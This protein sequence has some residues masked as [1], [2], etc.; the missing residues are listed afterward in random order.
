MQADVLMQVLWIFPIYA[1]LGWCLEVIYASV[2]T[3]KFVNR[4]FLNGCIC[5]IYG[6]GASLMI[7]CLVPIE[8][9]L[10]VLFFGALL[11]GSLLE[12][13]GGFLLKHLFHITW[14]DY[15]DEPL[16][17]GGYICL[18][19]SLAWGV[20]GIFLVRIIHPPIADLVQITPPILRT[21]LL[22]VFY[23]YFIVD[24]LLTVL[25]VLKLNRDLQEIT[26]LSALIQKSGD[27]LAKGIG[28]PAIEAARRIGESELAEKAKEL[29]ARVQTA[30]EDTRVKLHA[31]LED[32]ERLTAL[33]G[34]MQGARL[35]LFKAFPNM[36]ASQNI[37]ALHEMKRRVRIHIQ[38]NRDDNT[39]P[40]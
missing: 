29:T 32:S 40:K 30:A 3:G 38:K 24:V 2:V 17:I 34:N 27:A 14:W 22:L 16:N 21:S 7:L 23:V 1:L 11:L 28:T 5:P 18:K 25:T 8:H 19:F 36:K 6:L 13:I 26:R 4:G 12:L 10:I 37:G 39:S 33:L 9:N 15:S 20:A 35:R 31:K